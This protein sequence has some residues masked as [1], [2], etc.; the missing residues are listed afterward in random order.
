VPIIKQTATDH[1]IKY[2]E[3]SSFSD[4][5]SSHFKLLKKLGHQVELDIF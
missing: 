2:R 5:I 1:G 4:A 3:Y